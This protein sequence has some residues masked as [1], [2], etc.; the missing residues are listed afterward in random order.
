MVQRGG[1][2]HG[3]AG[4]GFHVFG[5]ALDGQLAGLADLVVG[6]QHCLDDDLQIG[7]GRGLP[8]RLDVGQALVV[9]ARLEQ[10]HVHHHVVDY[11]VQL[12]PLLGLIDLGA[13]GLLSGGEGQ[14]GAQAAARALQLLGH[15]LV[16]AGPA[17]AD[18]AVVLRDHLDHLVHVVDAGVQMQDAGLQHIGNV[19]NG[20]NS[21][22]HVFHI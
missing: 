8:H 14:G 6:E 10:A 16:V 22:C 15:I 2:A 13:G 1:I 7:V 19:V 3:E 17:E 5:A 21:F 20:Q 4:P 18:L 9:P 12:G 11:G